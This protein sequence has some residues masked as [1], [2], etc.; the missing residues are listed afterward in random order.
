MYKVVSPTNEILA[1]KR[2]QLDPS[3]KETMQ[4]YMN[5]ISLLKRLDGN[6][7][8]IRLIDSDTKTAGGN[9]GI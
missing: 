9:K 2:V 5:E 8:I 7:R 3:D 4:G 1:L 6:D